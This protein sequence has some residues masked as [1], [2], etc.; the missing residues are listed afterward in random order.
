MLAAEHGDRTLPS[1]IARADSGKWLV[2]VAAKRQA[3]TNAQSTIYGIKRLIGRR[4]DSN[5]VSE[6]RKVVPYRIVEGDN[7]DA[8]VRIDGMAFSPQEVSANILRRIKKLA[9]EQ[10]GDEVTEAVITVPAYFDDA[11]RRATKQAGEIARLDVL[12]ILN[13]PT[14][15]AL[16]YGP[17]RNLDDA[18]I[19]VF[20]LGG[21]TFDIS[22]L[23]VEQGVYEV[24]AT[25]GDTFLGG[26]D[27]DRLL[28]ELLLRHAKDEYD[29]QLSGDATALQRLKEAAEKAKTDLSAMTSV[30]IQIPFLATTPNG[31]VN[32][33]RT[34][35]RAELEE[36]T[37]P[38]IDRLRG[39]CERA[40]ADARRSPGDIEH[41]VLAGGMTRMPAIQSFVEQLFG[42]A[43]AK[44]VNP[45]EIVALGAAVHAAALGG[46]IEESVLLDIT[47]HA[48]GVKVESGRMSVVVERNTTVPTQESRVYKTLSDNQDHV[49]VEIYQG[50]AAQAE[51]N[52]YLG[53]FKLSGLPP[54]P[55][56]ETKVEVK[57]GLDTDGLLSVEALDQESG[58]TVTIK[59]DGGSGL[60]EAQ[61]ESLAASDGPGDAPTA[62]GSSDRV[63]VVAPTP[64]F[65]DTPPPAAAGKPKRKRTRTTG[66]HFTSEASTMARL[67]PSSRSR[68]RSDAAWKSKAERPQRPQRDEVADDYERARKGDLF[69]RLGLHWT[70]GPNQLATSLEKIRAKYGDGSPA[71]ISSPEAAA[72]LV[73]L[74]E[75][76]HEQLSSLTARR[77]YR[78]KVMQV[79]VTSAADLLDQ[80]A[81]LD[82]RRQDYAEAVDKLRAAMDLDPTNARNKNLQTL[83]AKARAAGIK[84]ENP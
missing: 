27:F 71:A 80:Q 73:A 7:G 75:T 60:T 12:G 57:F 50:D 2:G 35:A 14:A 25:N 29:T 59:I 15:A 84:L 82:I 37:A 3:V 42:A 76:A 41:V 56:G 20:D 39:P 81:R 67:D 66:H 83:I 62:R 24:L 34:L 49:D 46:E 63:P 48:L 47:P 74:A 17:H 9:A 19:A 23:H 4:F 77:N 38:L 30:D 26:E 58:K 31:P 28:I 54:R 21:G 72:K 51:E 64:F 18:T 53:R 78:I 1:M 79:D 5:E 69:G 55:A 8:W 11:Q 70:D 33:Q 32:F 16:A 10:L 43:P 52:R 61:V 44:D 45:D 6:L 13:E 40:L 68:R 65:P 22:I 36:L